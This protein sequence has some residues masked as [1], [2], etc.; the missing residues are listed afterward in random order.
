MTPLLKLLTRL[1]TGFQAE[2]WNP[3][4]PYLILS[5]YHLWL[6]GP[7]TMSVLTRIAIKQKTFTFTL[8][9]MSNT[10]FS[11]SSQECV[12]EICLTCS[13]KSLPRKSAM[14]LGNLV[15]PQ[16]NLKNRDLSEVVS[17][18]ITSQNHC[19]KGALASIPLYVATDF[20]RPRGI[21][22]LPHTYNTINSW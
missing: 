10:I 16:T 17:S 13:T 8:A 6:L 11:L 20:K 22:G 15:L 4:H 7:F 14:V 18:S 3:A 1:V 2:V 9:V 19:T 5:H 21:S 12:L